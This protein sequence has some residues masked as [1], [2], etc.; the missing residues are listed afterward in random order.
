MGIFAADIWADYRCELTFRDKLMG[1]VPKDPRIIE[2]WLRKK[3]GLAE[4]SEE[5][6]QMLLRT[7]NELGAE[8]NE[9][10][11]FDEMV[12]ASKALASV[13]QTNGF[14]VHPETRQLCV[15]G[16]CVKAMLKEAANV[17]LAGQRQGPTSKGVKAYWAEQIFV[18]PDF[19]PLGVTEPTSVELFIG[20][21]TGPKGRQ[22][23]LTYHEYVERPTFDLTV[24]VLRDSIPGQVWAEVWTYAEE[25]GFGAL[26][27]QGFGRFDVVRWERI[28]EKP[29]D[30]KRGAA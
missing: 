1:G 4:D 11:T 29:R 2:G 28:S 12:E 21:T 18:D 8:V 25:N 17:W 23:N 27:S 9:G 5:L 3:M 16:R 13:K 14:K 24:R 19:I 26:R 22:S 15:E 30:L 7:L 10:M 20:H 6:R